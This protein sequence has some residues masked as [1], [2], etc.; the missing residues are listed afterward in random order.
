MTTTSPGKISSTIAVPGIIRTTG[1]VVA[2]IRTLRDGSGFLVAI[3]IAI[4]IVVDAPPY[5]FGSAAAAAFRR[6]AVVFADHLLLLPFHALHQ[7]ACDRRIFRFQFL[8]RAIRT[9]SRWDRPICNTNTT[10]IVITG[11]II[12]MGGGGFPRS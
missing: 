2:A 11:I 1:T 8:E 6:G 4:V 10:G 7:V 12:G 9:I 3:A 5:F